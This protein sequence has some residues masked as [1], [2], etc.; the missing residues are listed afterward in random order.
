MI[1]TAALIISL[2]ACTSIHDQAAQRCTE[3]GLPN[4]PQCILTVSEN[5]RT[6]QQMALSAIA[7]RPVYQ[8]QPIHMAPIQ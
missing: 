6:R 4:D 3:Y 5:I 8:P 2:A 1:R 7:S